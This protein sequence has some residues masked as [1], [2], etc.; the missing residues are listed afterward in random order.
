MQLIDNIPGGPHRRLRRRQDGQAPKDEV[1]G[2]IE[3]L[4]Q[5]FELI[6]SNRGWKPPV[7]EVYGANETANGELGFYIISAT[8]APAPGASRPARRASSTTS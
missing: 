7:A 4:I 1:Y 8:A 2:S 3:G 5:H 6:M